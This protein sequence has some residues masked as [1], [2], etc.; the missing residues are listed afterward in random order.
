MN[1]LYRISQFAPS[2]LHLQHCRSRQRSNLQPSTS[3]GAVATTLT[4]GPNPE[5]TEIGT[6][7]DTSGVS[8]GFQLKK[9][10]FTSFDPPGSTAT[11]PNW[12][13]PQGTIVGGYVDSNGVNHGFVFQSGT[14]TTVDYSTR[15]M[16]WHHSHESQPFRKHDRR[17]V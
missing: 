14:F 17:M 11:T 6:Y 5:G 12:I 2:V 1:R 9:G 15:A 4:G 10:I 3:P 7:T 13:S 16:R 8:H